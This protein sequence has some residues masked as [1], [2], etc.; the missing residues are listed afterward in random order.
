MR[1]LLLVFV[2]AL[3]ALG[4]ETD[5]F[6]VTPDDAQ[7]HV[8][9]LAGYLEEAYSYY[10][11]KGLAP[12][13]PC[14]GQKYPVYVDSSS[15]YDAYT[16]LGGGCVVKLVF[17]PGYTKRLVFHEVV[18]VFLERYDSS[19]D[20]F[21]GDEAT[22]EAMA[23]VATGVYYF[24]NMYFSEK[25][26]A[27]NPFSLGEDRV[28][29]W[30]KYSA[31]V[32]WY[33]ENS[34][35]EWVL[36]SFTSRSGA[37][38]LYVNFLLAFAKGVSLGGVRYEPERQEVVVTP[39]VMY[40]YPDLPG[41][42]A[43]Y[44]KLSFPQAG[45]VVRISL[46][47]PNVVSNI[48]LNKDVALSNDTL[49]MA[50]VNN[51]S[52]TA[53]LKITIYYTTLR[54]S[55]VDGRYENGT[56]R[57]K[58][59]VDQGG[60][61]TG[62][63]RIND[64]DVPFADGIGFFNFTGGLRP[65]VLRVEYGGYTAYLQLNLTQP[66]LSVTPATLYL[67]AGGYGAVNVTL[68]N[69]NPISVS[70]LLNGSGRGVVFSPTRVSA[71]PRSASVY[72]LGFKALGNASGLA[73]VK[74]GEWT[75][76]LRLSKF[77]YSLLYDLDKESGE[78][79]AVFGNDVKK[80]A[81][82][83]LPAEVSLF[84]GGYV[85]GVV[86]IDPPSIRAAARSPRLVG[87][88]VQYTLSVEVVGA[89]WAK[90]LGIISIDGT[91][92]GVY[93]GSVLNLTLSLRPGESREV[94]I[95]VGRLSTTLRV[96][97]PT[98]R[99]TVVPLRAVVEDGTASIL[100]EVR[101]NIE[102]AGV[103][104][105][106]FGGAGFLGSV[107]IGQSLVVVKYRY[108]E[109]V[110]IVYSSPGSVDVVKVALPRP[111]FQVSLVKGVV[112]PSEFRGVFN[113]TVSV[114]GPSIDSRYVLEAGGRPIVVSARAGM[115]GV[116]YTL[117]E[118]HSGYA[119]R[120]VALFD[121]SLGP[122]PYVLSL[123]KPRVD[124]Q[125]IKWVVEGDAERAA[126]S[127]LVLTPPNYTY[128]V[129]GREVRGRV[130]INTTVDAI[131]GAA[132]VNYGFGV[133]HL[134]RPV[135]YMSANPLA[136]EVGVNASLRL[137]VRVPQGLYI[138]S[139]LTAST[140]AGVD[141]SLKSG[142]YTLNLPVKGNLPGVYNVSL[143]LGPYVNYT[144]VVFYEVKNLSLSAPSLLPVGAPAR[145]SVSGFVS[146]RV[147]VSV[148]VEA[149]GCG[150]VKTAVPLNYTFT[151]SLNRTCS[152]VLK[153]YTNR[154]SVSTVVR[155]ASLS[156][157]FNF[158]RLGILH[159]LPLFPQRGIYVRAVLGGVPVEGR[160][161]LVGDFDRLGLVNLT[162]YVEYMGVVNSTSFVGFAVPAGSYKAALKTAEALPPDARPFFQYLL[163]RAVATG[164]WEAVDKI[165][166][167]YADPPT[168]F[169]IA[170]RYL[171]E[172]SL[173]AGKEPNVD[174]ALALQKVEPAVLGVLGGVLLATVRRFF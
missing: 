113:I 123:P 31:V 100:A 144:Q 108:N 36:R 19:Q 112:S 44:Y 65:Y 22:P 60:R 124:A 75:A 115:C 84:Y 3:A 116:N 43:A 139:R 145:I 15:Q 158:T 24:P 110:D 85:A 56:I 55:L 51:S 120:V 150:D 91:I 82:E 133:I 69:P 101:Y 26:Y 117:A 68:E 47:S 162:A 167:L 118:W 122:V 104:P 67:G 48:A 109:T 156:A 140:G 90:F 169:T 163:E 28:Y 147:P 72:Q 78:L 33:L 59:Y 174:A 159:G 8:Q 18:H 154:T 50:V 17:K 74:C 83:K 138:N 4:L 30:Y 49:L 81:V 70:C 6:V 131:G 128:I 148:V 99:V 61:V 88:L 57:L 105:V 103:L 141:V 172:Q 96:E 38:K 5:H 87:G 111:S 20:Y 40:L 153:A 29:D 143:R 132:T 12:A 71:P 97:A 7:H 125:L 42:A 14:Q 164:Q 16:Q 161:V 45:G 107:N 94:H 152:A 130:V 136:A 149:V 37:A 39:G 64:T 32:A 25:L 11:S 146:P 173:A 80:Y 134:Q 86:K 160:V 135:L 89:P 2:L 93:N 53:Q 79:T 168:P 41:Y 171:V 137:C 166:K 9:V 23:S 170:A 114:C 127:L 27:V 102:T 142:N 34:S 35:W 77:S 63:V 119:E 76:S 126:V 106:E 95:S 58:L 121:T 165:S 151:V 46:D 66:R 92:H 52:N 157:L 98:V 73:V 54:V 129:L 21:W 62:V 13:P 1:W 10:T 155:W